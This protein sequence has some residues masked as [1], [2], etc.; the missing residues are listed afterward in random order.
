[1]PGTDGYELIQKIRCLP[2]LDLAR[3]PAVALTAFA[4]GEDRERALLAG[5]DSH[6][7]KP[8]DGYELIVVVAALAGVLQREQRCEV[9]DVPPPA[10]S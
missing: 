7:A 6:I 3:T 9:V 4:R 1:M 8:V 10:E 5:F 2:D